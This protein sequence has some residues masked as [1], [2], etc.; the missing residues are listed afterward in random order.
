MVTAVLVTVTAQ[1]LKLC[2][3][4]KYLAI[5]RRLKD[6]TI[7]SLAL[8]PNSTLSLSFHPAAKPLHKASLAWQCTRKC[9]TKKGSSSRKPRQM[10]TALRHGRRVES[11]VTLPQQAPLKKNPK[12]VPG[13]QVLAIFT[14][15]FVTLTRGW[16]S[17]TGAP[18]LSQF[19]TH[20]MQLLNPSL[21][22]QIHVG[23]TSTWISWL[24]LNCTSQQINPI[25]SRSRRNPHFGQTY[26]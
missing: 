11:H 3:P 25:P 4:L 17:G 20:C 23:C 16:D 13:F 6:W 14:F 2:L 26:Q 24:C 5:T 19:A 15:T 21:L 1:T 22:F 7:Q 8:C 12:S 18:T 9:Y 10:I